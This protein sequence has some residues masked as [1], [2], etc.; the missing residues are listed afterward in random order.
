MA[1]YEKNRIWTK[2]LWGTHSRI[3]PQLERNEKQ[4]VLK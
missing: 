1:Q 2:I 4:I 3:A